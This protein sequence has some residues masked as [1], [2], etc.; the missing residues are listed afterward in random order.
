MYMCVNA[1]ILDISKL[2]TMALSKH[3]DVGT[4]INHMGVN[5]ISS[6]VQ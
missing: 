1:Q 3:K 5:T 2:F 6:L 4:V